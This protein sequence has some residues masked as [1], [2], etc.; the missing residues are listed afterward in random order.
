MK[1]S[2]ATRT[3]A[4]KLRAIR[5]WKD[6]SQ[7]DILRLVYPEADESHRAL[8]SQW[9]NARREPPRQALIRYKQI[10]GVS[11]D[12]LLIDENDLPEDINRYAYKYDGDVR[13][14]R[15][16]KTEL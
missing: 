2:K 12:E 13:K 3:L 15:R 14:K 11:F 4:G 9:E 5:L 1:K 6:L 8:V 10:A 7:S 16:P